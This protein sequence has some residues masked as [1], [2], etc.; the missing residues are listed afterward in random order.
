MSHVVV[1][2]VELEGGIVDSVHGHGSVE[3]LPDT[4]TSEIRVRLR[5]RIVE[6]NWIATKVKGLSGVV[7]FHVFDLS[8]SDGMEEHMSAELVRA[9]LVAES[10]DEAVLLSSEAEI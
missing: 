7:N 6:M 5:V 8:V 9:F 4:E 3:G 2:D 1:S 10:V